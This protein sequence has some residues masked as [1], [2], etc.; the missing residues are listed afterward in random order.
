MSWATSATSHL[1]SESESLVQEALAN[2]ARGRTVFFI[3]HRL[4]T[5]WHADKI[6]VIEDGEIVET[7]RHDELLAGDGVYRRLYQLQL[8]P[9]EDRGAD[10]PPLQSM[11]AR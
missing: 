11:Q 6:V 5:I 10:H 8:G 3:A 4:S 7:G 1:D 2:V 9:T